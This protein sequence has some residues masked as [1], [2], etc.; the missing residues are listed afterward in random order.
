MVAAQERDGHDD[1]PSTGLFHC[2]NPKASVAPTFPHQGM[3]RS[4]TSQ[5]GAPSGRVSPRASH[6]LARFAGVDI[7]PPSPLLLKIAYNRM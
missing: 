4:R 6:F 5:A 1:R 2:F 3:E 7:I